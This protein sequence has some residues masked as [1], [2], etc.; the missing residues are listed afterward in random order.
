MLLQLAV[1]A[2]FGAASH[3]VLF[4]PGYFAVLGVF[5][6]FLAAILW[7]VW[8]TDALADRGTMLKVALKFQLAALVVLCA[9]AVLQL[10]QAA[11]AYATGSVVF[12]QVVQSQ[13]WMLM[14]SAACAV[15]L[16][17]AMGVWASV[18]ESKTRGCKNP[19]QSPSLERLR[20]CNVIAAGIGLLGAPVV[21][22]CLVANVLIG[23]TLHDYA[24]LQ[25]ADSSN[26]DLPDIFFQ[27]KGDR[28]DL[29]Y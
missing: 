8:H 19:L 12:L 17:Y 4:R 26:S 11:D 7:S 1:F 16:L 21:M 9:F 18:K 27:T 13:Q 10:M 24:A 14:V 20:M 5:G 23:S 3:L 29:E 22:P 6:S 15:V 28:F 25:T 2:T